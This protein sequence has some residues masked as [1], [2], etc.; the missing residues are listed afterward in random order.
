MF[1]PLVFWPLV[2]GLSWSILPGEHELEPE[3]AVAD[4]ISTQLLQ[5]SFWGNQDEDIKIMKMELQL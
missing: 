1:D 2:V 4:G 5:L 3:R